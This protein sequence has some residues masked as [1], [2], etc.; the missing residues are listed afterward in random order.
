MYTGQRLLAERVFH[1]RQA[2]RRAARRPDLVFRDATY[3]DH[4]PWIRPA[5]QRLGDVA[6]KAVLDCGC[7]HG[8][9]AVVLARRGAAV[10]GIDLSVGYLEEAR[11]RAIANEVDAEFIQ[12]DAESLPFASQSFDAVWGSAILHHLDLRRAGPELHRILRPGG[13]AVCCEPWGGNPLLEFARRRLPYAGKHRTPDERPVRM[14]DLATLKEYFSS[15]DVRGY[16]LLGA[17]R[18]LFRRESRTGGWLDRV[19]ARLL[20]RWPA[21]ESWCRY[22]VL[23]LRR[24]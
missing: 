24:V 7:G 17:A 2:A 12:A 13:V 3:L 5:F 18:R 9:A 19:D 6:G 16:Q 11:R 20:S 21:M 23:T 14:A 8:M 22:V 4:E 1:D 10:T 15:I